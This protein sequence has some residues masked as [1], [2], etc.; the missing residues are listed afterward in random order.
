MIPNSILPTVNASLNGISAIL[1]TLGFLAIKRR[2]IRNHKRFMA[3]ALLSSAVFLTSYLIYH[4]RY[5]SV[6][7]PFE[8]FTRPIYYAILLPHVILAALMTPFIVILVWR[9]S[10][11][12]FERHKKL[13]RVVLPVWMFVSVTG[14]MVYAMLYL[15][16]YLAI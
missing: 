9:A 10:K 1:L 8:D 6:N 7:Y 3:A 13:A 4:A 12:E 11:G 15:R 2:D 14:V 16:T 5:G